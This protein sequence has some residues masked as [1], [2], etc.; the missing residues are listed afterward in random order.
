MT[1]SCLSVF[2]SG[3]IQTHFVCF[4]FLFAFVSQGESVEENANVVV[5]LLIRRPECF[6]PALRGEGGQ[7]LLAAMKE[8]IKISEDPALDLPK[9]PEGVTTGWESLP[10]TETSLFSS[11]LMIGVHGS[12]TAFENYFHK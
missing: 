1:S 10:L 12:K 2:L 5:K 7:G 4:F 9:T 11:Q 6:G 8:A 3:I